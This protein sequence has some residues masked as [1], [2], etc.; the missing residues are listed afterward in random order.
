MKYQILYSEK[1]KKL[2]LE[3]RCYIFAKFSLYNGLNVCPIYDR[4]GKNITL[5]GDL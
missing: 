1:K 5:S 2:V 3:C 4:I